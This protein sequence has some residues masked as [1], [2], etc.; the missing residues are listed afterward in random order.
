MSNHQKVFILGDWQGHNSRGIQNVV[1]IWGVRLSW[2]CS[3]P[4]AC[5]PHH[6]HYSDDDTK[7]M[8]LMII[9]R[10]IQLIKVTRHPASWE[11]I[12]EE[13]T[14]SWGHLIVIMTII[15]IMISWSSWSQCW[16]SLWGL[17][18]SQSSTKVSGWEVIC[19]DTVLFPEGGGQNSDHGELAGRKV[20]QVL[21]DDDVTMT[22]MIMVKRGKIQTMEN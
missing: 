22:I 9:V 4:G 16:W 20:L 8:I 18:S 19:E 13:R 17:W 21:A 7:S 14:S 1:I 3:F 5:H 15:E 10:D 6:H 12:S 2:N 11:V